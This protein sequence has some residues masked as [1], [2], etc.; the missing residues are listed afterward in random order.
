[1][2]AKFVPQNGVQSCEKGM[3]CCIFEHAVLC[4]AT[5][6]ESR[7]YNDEIK[8]SLD[9]IQAYSLGALNIIEL[10]NVLN[11][12][13]TVLC[14]IKVLSPDVVVNDSSLPRKCPF[15]LPMKYVMVTWTRKYRCRCLHLYL[16]FLR[17]ISCQV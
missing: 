7:Y 3:H 14:K 17:C 11:I 13:A 5:T 6:A 15:I 16:R 10:Y 9:K 2:C 4:L 8:N 1:M 12:S